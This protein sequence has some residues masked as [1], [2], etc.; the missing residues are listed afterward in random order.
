MRTFLFL[1]VLLVFPAFLFSDEKENPSIGIVTSAV[2]DIVFTRSGKSIKIKKKDAVYMDDEIYTRSGSIDIQMTSNAILRV[3]SQTKIKL[4]S[5]FESTKKDS[6][7]IEL[8]NGNLFSKLQKKQ[9]KELQYKI[10]TPNMI[11]GARGTEF[12]VSTG[13]EIVKTSKGI[14]KQFLDDFMVEKMKIFDTLKVMKEESYK[15]LKEQKLKNKS[16]IENDPNRKK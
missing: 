11:A 14:Q 9:G 10:I 13:E 3:G 5:I 15:L 2:G 6:I 12:I 4:K 8:L 1:I 7:L 16:L